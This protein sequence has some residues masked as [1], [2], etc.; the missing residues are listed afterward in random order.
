M[1]F[2]TSRGESTNKDIKQN[3]KLT[4]HKRVE[5][6]LGKRKVMMQ[7]VLLQTDFPLL[8]ELQKLLVP[9][10]LR[11]YCIKKL[12]SPVL[13]NNEETQ[14]FNKMQE[15]FL[16]SLEF[17]QLEFERAIVEGIP[18]MKDSSGEKSGVSFF[19]PTSKETL[20]GVILRIFSFKAQK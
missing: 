6:D 4:N 1:V 17:P 13:L 10:Q 15:E 3:K 8:P 2:S 16:I 18:R 9:I 14:L 7:A 12:T 19:C 20:F 11:S 5:R